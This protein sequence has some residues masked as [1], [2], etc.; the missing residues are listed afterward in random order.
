VSATLLAA[1]LLQLVS[2][3]LLRA[4]LGR[5]WLSRPFTLFVLMAIVFHGVSEV[6]IRTV[7]AQG[8]RRSPRWTVEQS[9]I[10]D[11]ALAASIGLFVAVVGYL[12]LVSLGASSPSEPVTG[13]SAWWPLDWRITGLAAAPLLAATVSGNGYGSRSALSSTPAAALVGLSNTFLVILV[14]LTAFSF[15]LKYGRR[16]LTPVLA[17]QSLVLAVGGQRSELF[18][19]AAV[20][21]VL[22][23]HV[24][25]RF[26]RR[27]VAIA[28]SVATVAALGITSARESVGREYFRDDSGFMGRSRAI[29]DGVWS[30]L[31]PGTLLSE[32]AH[33]FDGNVFAGQVDKS[34]R[35]GS[36]SELGVSSIL[37]SFLI[38]VPSVLYTEKLNSDRARSLEYQLIAKR[39]VVPIDY[40]PGSIGPY[41]G[42]VGPRGLPLLM[43]LVGLAFAWA[44]NWLFRKVTLNR[45][46]ILATLLQGVLFFAKELVGVA[47]FLRTGLFLVLIVTV[48]RGLWP[49]RHHLT[50]GG[51]V[52]T[53]E[54]IGVGGGRP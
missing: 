26:S 42:A 3:C 12:A 7:A 45:I 9:H 18:V 24:D 44:E 50:R 31:D 40:A 30:P 1:L 48:L 22:L 10:D 27:A 51:P 4:R 13:T 6:L 20:L 38:A 37:D 53:P 47:V 8:F 23:Y 43:L 19:G 32:L 25:I 54:P 17:V 29:A 33:R 35:T 41:L 5:R 16:W 2:V 28:L 14:V 39:N 34:V 21:L 11:A 46:L 36:G 52:L 49:L 15:V